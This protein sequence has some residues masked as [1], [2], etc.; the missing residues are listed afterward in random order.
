MAV[1]KDWLDESKYKDAVLSI[2]TG[3]EWVDSDGDSFIVI[4]K[5]N[6]V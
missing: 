5:V 1:T 3:S 4:S 6:E 2:T